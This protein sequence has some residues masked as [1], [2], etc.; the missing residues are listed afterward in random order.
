MKKNTI[1]QLDAIEIWTLQENYIDIMAVDRSDVVARATELMD[2]EITRSVSAEHGFCALVRTRREGKTRTMLFDFGFS[3]DGAARNAKMLGAPMEEVEVAV[4]SHGHRDH[5]GGFPGFGKMLGGS[6]P[7]VV[8]PASFRFRRYIRLFDER[9]SYAPRLYREALVDAGF[10]LQEETGPCPLLDGRALFLG[11]IE[12]TTDFEKGR[13][14][15]FYEDNG[16]EKWDPIEDD[17]GVVMHLKDHGLFVLSGCA[18]SGIINTVNHARKITGVEK[19]FAVMGG[20]H[21]SGPLGKKVTPPTIA[22]IKEMQPEYVIP[23]HCTGRE[24]IRAMEKEMPGQFILNMSG[25]RLTFS[26]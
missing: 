14:N 21:I 18:H 22:A 12:R 20:F 10:V 16:E 4:L 2:W 11:E 25:T 26:A 9:K 13:K 17:T 19:V 24:A 1:A 23:C 8:H 3:P 5:F 7:L 6:I 15:I